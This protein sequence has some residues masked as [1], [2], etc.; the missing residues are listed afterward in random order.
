MSV[1][2]IPALSVVLITPDRYERLRP[3]L[4]CL[5]R[6]TIR[7][8]IELIIVA[9]ALPRF[10]P[11]ELELSKFWKFRLVEVGTIRSTGEPRAAGALMASAPVVA[12]GED[13]CWPEPEWAEALLEA[14]R[15]PYGGVGATLLNGNPDSLSSWASFLLNFGP[16]V[17]RDASAGADYIPTHNS[18]FKT[19]LLR[20]YGD[21]LGSALEIEGLLQQELIADGHPLFLQAK[22]RAAHINVSKFSLLVWEQYWGA[23]FFWGSRVHWQKWSAP[24]RCL[25][26][27]ATPALIPLRAARAFKNARRIGLRFHR[28]AVLCFCLTSGALALAAGAFVGLLFGAGERAA[29]ARVS[30]EFYRCRY[31]RSQDKHLLP[32]D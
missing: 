20:A 15:R 11:D 16:C 32:D 8:R 23:R 6:Q 25:W 22:A 7:N 2:E 5:S 1:I 30:M 4:Q 13:H 29:E 12:F 26:A 17:E 21:R 9:P 10:H 18:S 24:R 28:L 27:L 19:D 31:L 3:T 14:H